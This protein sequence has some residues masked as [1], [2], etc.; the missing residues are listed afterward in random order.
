M[1]SSL[2]ASLR[3]VDRMTVPALEAREK[4]EFI[5]ATDILA[6]E[7]VSASAYANDM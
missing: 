1:P 5:I 4:Q 6:Q 7:R 3:V 2:N